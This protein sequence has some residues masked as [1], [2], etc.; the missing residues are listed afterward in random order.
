MLETV[1]ESSAAVK[2]SARHI[3]IPPALLTDDR[4]SDLAVRVYGII[5]RAAF[6]GRANISV[7][8]IAE[9][10]GL[11]GGKKKRTKHAVIPAL[12]Q[13]DGKY[14][15]KIMVGRR[16]EYELIGRPQATNM[17]RPDATDSSANGRPELPD[18]SS[19]DP[20][21]GRPAATLPSNVPSVIPNDDD[22][23]RAKDKE[24]DDARRARVA[25]GLKA[26]GFWDEQIPGAIAVERIDLTERWLKF[27]I[28][29]GKTVRWVVKAIQRGCEPPTPIPTVSQASPYPE[30]ESSTVGISDD[31]QIA[32]EPRIEAMRRKFGRSA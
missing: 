30:F 26:L 10:L 6:D 31:D 8:K 14:I 18:R 24:S 27:G 3:R 17:G 11:G 15:T 16:H 12:H 20:A 9:R 29:S 2:T 21:N 32:S 28:P 4:I 5:V 22:A 13:L 23:A 1:P 7:E 19:A 25:S